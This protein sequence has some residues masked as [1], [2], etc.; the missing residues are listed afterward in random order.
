MYE[1]VATKLFP[2][3]GHDGMNYYNA[4]AIELKQGNLSIT[5]LNGECGDKENVRICS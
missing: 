5:G 2:Y 3:F 4:A 1:I